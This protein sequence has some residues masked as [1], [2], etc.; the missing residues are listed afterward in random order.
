MNRAYVTREG[1]WW[2]VI[3][4]GFNSLLELIFFFLRKRALHIFHYIWT[5]S[6]CVLIMG[7]LMVKYVGF[8]LWE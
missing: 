7:G 5:L 2:F 6:H 1:D 4:K 3:N 8:M